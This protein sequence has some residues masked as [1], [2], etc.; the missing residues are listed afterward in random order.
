MNTIQEFLKRRRICLKTHNIRVF[1][2]LNR[3][4]SERK[5]VLD[6]KCRGR[7][8]L[9]IMPSS[10]IKDVLL[11]DSTLYINEKLIYGLRDIT[12]LTLI[13]SAI[14]LREHAS[15]VLNVG[16][17]PGK[18]IGYAVLVSDILVDGG[19]VSSM[20]S[21]LEVLEEILLHS[22][23]T[24]CVIK[25]G[26]S[27]SLT[28]LS[29]IMHLREKVEKEKGLKVKI[30]LVDESK[31]REKAFILRD[32]VKARSKDYLAACTIALSIGE[33]LE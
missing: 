25:V 29:L 14:L 15:A 12:L 1:Y 9:A 22:P 24:S 21:L 4:F 3:I 11:E 28:S 7:F 6:F 27:I 30:C 32:H 13:L 20:K 5:L 26:S 33:E 10:T 31:S 2:R 19:A 16:I 8:D 23:F 17:D 18:R